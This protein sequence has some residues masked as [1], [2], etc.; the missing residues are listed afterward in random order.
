MIDLA[1]VRR[2]TGVTQVELASRLRTTQGGVSRIERQSDWRLSTLVAYLD[3]LGVSA[4]LTVSV[5]EESFIQA[6]NDS[7]DVTHNG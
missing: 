5:G 3:A 7:G 1:A 6:L 4:T 2:A